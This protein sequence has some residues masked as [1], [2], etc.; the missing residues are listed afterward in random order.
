MGYLSPPQDGSTR[1][2]HYED[3]SKGWG[4]SSF[5][6]GCIDDSCFFS[7]SPDAAKPPRDGYVYG[8]DILYMY[9]AKRVCGG[10]HWGWFWCLFV[11]APKAVLGVKR[12]WANSLDRTG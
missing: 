9:K 12:R 8:N 1:F 3:E 11:R 10:N 5:G 6:T 2:L 7:Y 4:L